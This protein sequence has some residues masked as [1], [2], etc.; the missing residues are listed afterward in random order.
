MHRFLRV[1]GGL[2]GLVAIGIL[3]AALA[4]TFGGQFGARGQPQV[5]QQPYPPPQT[6]TPGAYPPPGTPAPTPTPFP[7]AIPET[8]PTPPQQIPRPTEIVLTPVPPEVTDALTQPTQITTRPA[9]RSELAVD[10]NYVVWRSYEDGQTNIVAYNL[11]TGEEQ[12]IS[13]LPGGKGAPSIDGQYVVWDEGYVTDNDEVVSEI[14]AYNLAEHEERVLGS[15]T[16]P[17][18]SGQIVVWYDPWGDPDHPTV[19]HNLAGGEQ[20]RLATVRGGGAEISGNWIAYG[21]PFWSSPTSSTAGSIAELHAY[22]LQTGEDVR[23]GRFRSRNDASQGHEFAISDELVIWKGVRETP[24]QGLVHVYDLN[25]HQERV[26]T[27]PPS[28]DR[29]H[30][31]QGILLAGAQAYNVDR[32]TKARIFRSGLQYR[33]DSLAHDGHTVAW[34]AGPNRYE[35]QVY[36]A[37]FRRLP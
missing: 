12:R 33:L 28:F 23:L 35:M 1:M 22:N 29:P 30:L 21:L 34:T 8:P 16:R 31:A 20:Y 25:T 9:S 19:I 11:A 36:V 37:Q 10:G 5:A 26:L 17:G 18:I 3:L 13:S 15:G 2:A 4:L 32:G 7:T 14:R 6:P 27:D 24:E